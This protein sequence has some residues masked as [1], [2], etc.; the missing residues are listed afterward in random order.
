MNNMAQ[1]YKYNYIYDPFV[2]TGS[3]LL[4][5]SHYGAYCFGSEIDNRIIS[6]PIH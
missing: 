5:A 1:T 2:G 6:E 4:A 3:L